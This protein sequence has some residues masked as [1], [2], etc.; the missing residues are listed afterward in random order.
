MVRLYQFGKFGQCGRD[1]Q[2]GKTLMARYLCWEK[3]E[4][5]RQ[6]VAPEEDT[7]FVQGEVIFQGEMKVDTLVEYRSDFGAHTDE[8]RGSTQR[9]I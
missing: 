3:Q 5:L 6:S 8:S 7:K 9:L 4:Y 1:S 2:R